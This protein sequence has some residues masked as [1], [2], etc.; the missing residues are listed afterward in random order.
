MRFFIWLV[1]NPDT[2]QLIFSIF[3]RLLLL[4]ELILKVSSLPIF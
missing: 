3:D 4:V 2:V 1:L